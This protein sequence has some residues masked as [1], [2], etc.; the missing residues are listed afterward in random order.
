M[1][2]IYPYCMHWLYEHY[3]EQQAYNPCMRRQ[4]MLFSHINTLPTYHKYF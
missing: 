3:A 1:Y 4:I 2:G